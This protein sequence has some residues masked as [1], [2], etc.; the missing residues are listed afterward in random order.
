MA[1]VRAELIPLTLGFGT[2]LISGALCLKALQWVVM[3][4]RLRPFAA[5]C[6]LLGLGAIVFG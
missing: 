2:A 3:R 5:Y 1:A 4:R 6:A